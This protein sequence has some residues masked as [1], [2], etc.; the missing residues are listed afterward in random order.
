M[1]CVNRIRR[2]CGYFLLLLLALVP[3]SVLAASADNPLTPDPAAEA[4]PSSLP[5][6]NPAQVKSE[7]FLEGI[8]FGAD[9]IRLRSVSSHD[10]CSCVIKVQRRVGE[11]KKAR[12]ECIAAMKTR[13]GFTYP[14]AELGYYRMGKSSV[15][16]FSR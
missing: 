9:D 15:S 6:A 14:Q 8:D 13:S 4:P 12:W 2:S 3:G 7:A 10:G 1:T 11:G 5:V 16:M